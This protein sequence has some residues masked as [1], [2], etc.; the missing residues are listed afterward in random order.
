MYILQGIA[1][2]S[3]SLQTF[4]VAD[5]NCHIREILDRVFLYNT[6]YDVVKL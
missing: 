5:K 6:R 4:I 3:Y 1:S 2:F